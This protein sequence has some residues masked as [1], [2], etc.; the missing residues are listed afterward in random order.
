[1]TLFSF[2]SFDIKSFFTPD[3]IKQV[4]DFV[5]DVYL[6]KK[7]EDYIVRLIDCTR[8]PKEYK[9]KTAQ[10]LS[11]GAS[12]RGTIALFIASKGRAFL[13]GRTYVT[14]QDVKEV[15]HLTLRHRI[16]LNYEG[17]AEEIK[18]D[19]VIDEILSVVS[20]H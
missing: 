17:Q 15:A 3:L 8:N 9:L 14:P 18:V 1:M 4:Q 19:D 11:F 6:D 16:T 13:N 5:K 2:D 20:I 10:Y 12:P 7:I